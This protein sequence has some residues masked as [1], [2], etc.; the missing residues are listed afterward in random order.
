MSSSRDTQKRET[1]L[2]SHS[3]ESQ[4][5]MALVTNRCAYASLPKIFSNLFPHR[6]RLRKTRRLQRSEEVSARGPARELDERMGGP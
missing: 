6:P 4:S 2:R 3:F 1:C 5:S